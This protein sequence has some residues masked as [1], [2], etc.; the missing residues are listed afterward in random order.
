MKYFFIFCVFFL[1]LDAKNHFFDR[2]GVF[3]HGWQ[4]H[5]LLTPTP[6]KTA[7]T[8]VLI[9]TPPR[10]TFNL[11]GLRW[12][13]GRK[14]WEQYMNSHPNVDCYF[15]QCTNPRVGEKDQVW[16]E[17]NILFVGD[18]WY[19][20]YGND[21]ILHK[22]IVALEKLL[23]KYTHFIRTNVNTFL[24]LDAVDAYMATHHKTFYTTPLW[25]KGWYA[26]GYGIMFTKEVAIH[27]VKEYHR[28]EKAGEELISCRHADDSALTALATGVW[29]LDKIHPFR[30]SPGLPFGVRQLMAKECL[31]RERL[32]PYA[33]YLLPPISLG[34]A[35]LI[36]HRASETIMLYRTK[37]GLTLTE[38]AQF[39]QYLLTKHYPK[40]EV[41]DLVEYVQ[42]LKKS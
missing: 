41:V 33:A 25:E 26:I 27:L 7:C 30:C 40:L 24:N 18:S 37:G 3:L 4:G 20:K 16:L 28:L 19:E 34:E 5:T 38:L 32:N 23:P 10:T 13:L 15:L 39:Y 42:G 36:S 29:P 8:A 21:R 1:E 6:K 35:I 22:T 12:Q 31:G 2:E 9:I 17:G 14:T 11:I